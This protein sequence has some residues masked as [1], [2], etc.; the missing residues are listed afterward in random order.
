MRTNFGL[1]LKEKESLCGLSKV[2]VID[3][4]DMLVGLEAFPIEIEA[5]THECSAMGFIDTAYA[6]MID[7]DYAGSGLIDFIASILDDMNNENESC[8]YSFKGIPIYLSR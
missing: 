2:E 7:F 5:K 8:E 6:D 4:Y 3:L 1:V